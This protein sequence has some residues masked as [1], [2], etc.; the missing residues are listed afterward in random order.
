MRKNLII[1]SMFCL[2]ACDENRQAPQVA[3]VQ[4]STSFSDRL[5]VSKNRE[6]TLSAEARPIAAD[7]LAYITAQNEI[8]NLENRTGTEI[9]ESSNNLMQI[10]ENLR[11]SMPD[12]L[13]TK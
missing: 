12:T 2:L 10:M 11:S 7:W 4:S 3:P 6:V 1:F 9:M 8:E 13:R 5:E